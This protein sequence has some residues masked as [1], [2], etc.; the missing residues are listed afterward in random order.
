MLSKGESSDDDDG[1]A[2]MSMSEE[3]RCC[4]VCQSTYVFLLKLIRQYPNLTQLTLL[5]PPLIQQ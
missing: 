4:F 1:S 2:S 5:S 3:S